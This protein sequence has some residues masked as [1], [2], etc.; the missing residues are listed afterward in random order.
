M[1]SGAVAAVIARRGGYAAPRRRERVPGVHLNHLGS[2]GVWAARVTAVAL[3]LVVV[4]LFATLVARN[5][6]FALATLGGGA[7]FL[8]YVIYLALLKLGDAVVGYRRGE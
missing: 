7:A 5:P 6:T 8:T 3:F 2:R 1:W 4:V